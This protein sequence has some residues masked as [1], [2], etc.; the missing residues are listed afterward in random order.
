MPY[1]L[2]ID[3]TQCIGCGAC[4]SACQSEHGFPE[5]PAARLDEKNLTALE[6]YGD[7]TVR[8]M[9]RHCEHPTCVSVCPV[10]AM[11]K[12]PQGPVNYDATKCLGCRYCML[13]C[14][15]DIPKYEWHNPAP[16][17][18]KC[19]MC[20][21]ERTSKGRPTACS[22]ACPTGATKFGDR[23]ELLAEAF[24][25]IQ[26]DPKTYVPRVYGDTAAGGTSVLYLS[27]VPFEKLGFSTKVGTEPLPELTW[28]V[29][30]KIP[31]V[32]VTAGVAF[33]AI[34]WIT[35]RR[36]EVRRFEARQAGNGHS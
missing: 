7:V 12:T 14:P 19:T 31:D 6:R 30:E 22:E 17:V 25:R 26:A 9:C 27:G 2:L 13:A 32:V 29:L 15:F 34:H 11:Y 20:Y 35:S 16:R 33:A 24:S 5:Q 3:I 18:R 28:R 8:R 4:V 23:A 1:A 21:D 36:D 10:G